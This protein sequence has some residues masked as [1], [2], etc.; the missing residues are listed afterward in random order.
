MSI[1]DRIKNLTTTLNQHNINYYVYDSPTISDFEY[2][3]LLR[4][5]EELEYKNPKYKFENSPSNRVGSNPIKEFGTI[6][7]RIPML[8]LANAMNEKELE[9]FNKQIIKL[10][11]ENIEYVAE[12]KLDGLAVELVYENGKFIYGSTRGDGYEGENITENLKTIRG[13]PLSLVGNNIPSLL[14][15]RGEVF[16]NK[17]DF[18]KLNNDRIKQNLS[19]FANPRNCAAGSLRQLDSKITSKRPLRIYCYGLGEFKGVDFKSQKEF[20]NYLPKWGFPVNPHIELGSGL[21]FLIE[22]YK[23]AEKLRENIDYDIDGVVFKVNSYRIQKKLGARSK[24]PRWA[25]AGKFK[26]EQGMTRI[27]DIQISVGRTGALTP[28]AKLKPIKVGGVVISNAT[29]HNQDEINKKDIRINDYVLIQRAG[30]VIPEIIKVIKE[31]RSNNSRVFSI[32]SKCP[33]CNTEAYKN[34][35]EAVLRCCNANCD[36]IIKGKI[37]HYVSK[38]CMDISGLGIK[39]IDLLIANNL[40]NNISDIYRLKIKDLKNLQRMGQKSAENIINSINQSKKTTLAKFINGLGIRNV[41]LNASKLLE[42]NFNNDIFRLINSN[43]EELIEINEIGEIM[44]NSIIEYFNN[45]ENIKIINDC[46]SFNLNFNKSEVIKETIFLDKRFAF[47]GSLKKYSR[48]EVSK[49]IESYGG[50]FSSSV[51]KKTDYLITG[52]KSGGKLSKAKSLN[53]K[54]LNEEEF[55]DLLDKI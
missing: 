7:H 21:N 3:I 42:K 8:S 34:N 53:I 20:L 10:D 50:Y 15:V 39:I 18:K 33:I 25:I 19:P 1:K 30:D 55:L 52:N 40:L 13:I 29:L 36:A 37:E 38:N 22:Y 28:V 27:L 6:K 41:G 51:N 11:I 24:S 48:S 44:A 4:E 43:Y 9:D 12:L 46:L 31:K 2:D 32:P 47:T 26:A 49:I 35:N 17:H 45:N 16:I 23:S 54:V 14:E 5:L